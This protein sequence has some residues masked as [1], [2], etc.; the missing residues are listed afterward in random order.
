ME[1]MDSDRADGGGSGALEKLTT[2][3]TGFLSDA[4]N[5][6]SSQFLLSA[7]ALCYMDTDL[8]YWMWVETFPKLWGILSERQRT[9]RERGG[10]IP[11]ISILLLC[12]FG[13]ERGDPC[14]WVWEGKG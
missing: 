6:K 1:G 5:V 10:A 8:A 4:R 11:G 13:R 14:K 12:G 7:T 2:K 3:L 9:V